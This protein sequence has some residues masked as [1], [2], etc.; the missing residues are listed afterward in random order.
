MREQHVL[1]ICSCDA[2]GAHDHAR[3]MSGYQVTFCLINNATWLDCRVE[4]RT[5][6]CCLC[7]CVWQQLHGL[8]GAALAMAFAVSNGSQSTREKTL[9]LLERPCRTPE[10]AFCT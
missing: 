8:C 10:K 5:S 2:S 4:L 9:K 1:E 6:G 3:V 7:L